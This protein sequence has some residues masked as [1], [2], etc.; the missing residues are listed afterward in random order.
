MRRHTK[1]EV[2][3]STELQLSSI[4]STGNQ[5]KSG[6]I[7]STWNEA[8]LVFEQKGSSVALPFY[9]VLKIHALLCLHS[10]EGLL[11]D[12]TPTLIQLT[13]NKTTV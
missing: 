8:L 3:G 10:V 9:V 6:T 13:I 11:V 12:F 4:I 2:F 5:T 7:L 1:L